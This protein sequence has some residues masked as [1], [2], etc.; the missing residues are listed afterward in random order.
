M[1]FRLGQNRGGEGEEFHSS[2]VTPLHPLLRR[3]RGFSRSRTVRYKLE[4]FLRFGFEFI[5]TVDFVGLC[6]VI[7]DGTVASFDSSFS[8]GDVC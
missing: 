6:G 3:F 1:L 7:R 5:L 8:Y 2:S 4:L